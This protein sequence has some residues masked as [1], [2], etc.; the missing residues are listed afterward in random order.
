MEVV[1]IRIMTMSCHPWEEPNTGDHNQADLLGEPV[2]K[3]QNGDLNRTADEKSKEYGE[4][5]ERHGSLFEWFWVEL[6]RL[7]KFYH[8]YLYMKIFHISSK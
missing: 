7:R 2:S 3:S 6:L 4:T 8:I 5:T 1:T